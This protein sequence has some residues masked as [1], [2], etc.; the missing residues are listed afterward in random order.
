M[1]GLPCLIG[2]ISKRYAIFGSRAK[3]STPQAAA[4][5]HPRSVRDQKD[6]NGLEAALIALV[7][8][9][10]CGGV[11]DRLRADWARSLRFDDR[12]TVVAK[13]ETSVIKL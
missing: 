2:I 6:V 9:V 5:L 12:A 7:S 3:V 1:L 8:F 13:P 11:G 4:S 10:K